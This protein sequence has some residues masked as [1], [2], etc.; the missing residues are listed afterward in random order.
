[1]IAAMA[2]GS[3]A[4]RSPLRAARRVLLALALSSVPAF[5]F[6][7]TAASA[8]TLPCILLVCVP[9][10]TPVPTVSLPLPTVSVP[11]L[12]T[13]SLPLPTATAVPTLS[14]P[15]PTLTLPLPSA[16]VSLPVPVP[17]S[18][19]S[20]TLPTPTPSSPLTT[21]LGAG[22][23]PSS[24]VVN[25]AGVCVDLGSQPQPSP[26]PGCLNGSTDPTCVL[27]TGS[28]SPNPGGGSGGGGPGGSNRSGGGGNGSAAAQ[29]TGSFSVFS[30]G[31]L[32]GGQP[33]AA[34]GT[35]IPLGLT[36]AGIPAVTQLSPVSGL[37]FGHALI[38]WPLFGLL[39]V[40]G[41]AAVY[42]V[43]R[44]FRAVRPD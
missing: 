12:P 7:L 42:L 9:S 30:G 44:R 23:S 22:Q 28:G 6:S 43:V 14:L 19:D 13:L 25:L 27:G 15:A 38:L 1:M 40:L 11:P 41:L 5:G 37:Q 17:G 2:G 24:C 29:P 4:R 33:I 35:A 26:N 21:V 10:P 18:T 34:G 32:A 16:T 3:E 31:S 36:V 20:G 39:D 8:Q